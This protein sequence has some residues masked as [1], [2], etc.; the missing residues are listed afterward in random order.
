[1]TDYFVVTN[2]VNTQHGVYSTQERL[3][4]LG[5]TYS[6][7]RTLFPDAVII[8]IESGLP[9]TADQRETLVNGSDHLIDLTDDEYM[10]SIYTKNYNEHECKNVCESYSLQQISRLS[11][12]IQPSDRFTKI[13]GRYKLMPE[14][15]FQDAG[16]I[17]MA[18]PWDC[19][20]PEHFTEIKKYFMTPAILWDGLTH[21]QLMLALRMAHAEILWH[22]GQPDRYCDVE[23][24]LYK[25]LPTE[26]TNG[27]MCGQIGVTGLT[28]RDGSVIKV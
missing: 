12:D 7:I 24:A 28:G 27:V 22:I 17:T 16:K 13:T 15:K 2:A 23:H 10:Q 14:F 5:D 1:M 4:Q 25:H 26:I 19:N 8:T 11:L 20:W 21:A 9:M 6:S 3:Q 18:G